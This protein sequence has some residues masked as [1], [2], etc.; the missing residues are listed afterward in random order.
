MIE[1]GAG[2]IAGR[3]ATI[4]TSV[5]SAKISETTFVSDDYDRGLY[6]MT[7]RLYDTTRVMV[8]TI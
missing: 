6:G 2:T 3:S 5:I 7:K 8:F 1:W 4:L